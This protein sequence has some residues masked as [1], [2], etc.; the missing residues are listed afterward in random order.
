VHLEE[1][2]DRFSPS[3]EKLRHSQ[4]AAR[5]RFHPARDAGLC[6]SLGFLGP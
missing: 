4:L 3:A 6:T 5:S 2:N 1:I